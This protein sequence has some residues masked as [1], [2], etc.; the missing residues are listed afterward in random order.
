MDDGEGMGCGRGSGLVSCTDD[1]GAVGFWRLLYSPSKVQT[2]GGDDERST[3]KGVEQGTK[4]ICT[5]PMT[6]RQLAPGAAVVAHQAK[7]GSTC[8][9]SAEIPALRWSWQRSWQWLCITQVMSTLPASSFPLSEQSLDFR[10]PTLQPSN[11]RQ[12]A[13]L[14]VILTPVHIR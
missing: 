9:G 7:Q 13:D 2:L 1:Q 14:D 5:P 10:G 6:Q 8:R 4:W 11:L 3:K 12:K